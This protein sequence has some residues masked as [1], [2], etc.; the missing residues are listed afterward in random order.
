MG[1]I[2][3]KSLLNI[4]VRNKIIKII[5]NNDNNSSMFFGICDKIKLSDKLLLKIL[6]VE[7]N[8]L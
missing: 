6:L 1:N 4:F 7:K 3:E 2:T 5:R 8:L